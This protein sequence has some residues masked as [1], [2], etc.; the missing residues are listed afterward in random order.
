MANK[1]VVDWF[2]GLEDMLTTEAKLSGLL[3]HGSTIGQAREFVVTRILRTIL[4]AGVH[5]GSGKVIGNHGSSS[6]QIDIVVYDPRFP[7]MKVEGGGL[8]FIEGAL[9]TIEIKSTIDSD[10]LR[11]S[12]DNCKSVLELHVQGEYPEEADAQIRF[13]MNK[14]N[15]SREMAEARFQYMIRPATYVFA[16]NSK[17]SLDTTCAV[18]NSWLGDINCSSVYFPFLPRVITSGEIV[19]VSSDGRI[20][21]NATSGLEYIIGLFKTNRRFRWFAVHLMDSVSRR[22]G[23][24]NFAESFDY[25]ISEYYPFDAYIATL[26]G[27]ETRFIAPN[28]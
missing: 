26:E 9:A 3:E 14:G 27:A 1:A 19:G 7:F 12:L 23:L 22:L 16:F 21:I 4:P 6:K 2:D 11:M 28:D 8:Y 15:L 5:I 18:I 25:R 24:R 10:Q 17:L 13:Y 20:R